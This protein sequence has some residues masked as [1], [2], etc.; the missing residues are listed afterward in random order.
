VLALALLGGVWA[1]FG[2][3]FAGAGG[4]MGIVVAGPVTEEI[5]KIALIVMV[6]ETRPYIFT[7]R[8]QILLAAIASGAGF[9][10]IENLMY[11]RNQPSEL[12]VNWRWTVCTALH[13]GCTII[14]S[15]GAMRM[16]KR[17]V[18]DLVEPRIGLAV[19][20]IIAAAVI[21]GSYNGFALIFELIVKPF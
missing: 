9:A 3:I 17:S 4:V 12:L 18:S 15:M 1:V 7:S 13:I 14:A 20:A 5:M 21:H 6:V 19:P 16:W 11:L 2:A 8:F 10:I